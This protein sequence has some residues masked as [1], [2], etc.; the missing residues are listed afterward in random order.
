MTCC[1]CGLDWTALL[2]DSW[3]FVKTPWTDCLM[4]SSLWLSVVLADSS[5]W[6]TADLTWVANN[7]VW[8]LTFVTNSSLFLAPANSK[9]LVFKVATACVA[10][11]WRFARNAFKSGRAGAGCPLGN[12]L[13]IYYGKSKF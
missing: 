1:A 2:I 4:G 6:L 12:P 8:L 10:S 7:W 3:S 11:F 9:N 5:N 13:T